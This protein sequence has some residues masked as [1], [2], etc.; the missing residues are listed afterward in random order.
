MVNSKD[1]EEVINLYNSRIHSVV[2]RF[3]K[4][5]SNVEI[6]DVKQDVY[7]KVWKNL[8]KCR[9]DSNPW[10]WI[11]RITVNTCKDYLKSSKKFS[12]V[13][14]TEEQDIINTIP[15][16]KSETGKTIE[17]SERQKLILS[18]IN[19]LSKK[20]RDVIIYSDIEELTYEEIAN[21]VNCP[22]GTVKSRLFT[23]RKI[24]YEELKELIN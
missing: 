22:V 9:N 3:F 17:Q 5:D 20:Y 10:G 21:K 2:R 12:I 14:N 16:K 11:N 6:D 7:I 1:I 18:S 24:L 13:P 4:S 19:K 23:A 8:S 15:D